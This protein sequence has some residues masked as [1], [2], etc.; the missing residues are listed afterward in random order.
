MLALGCCVLCSLRCGVVLAAL[1]ASRCSI[2]SSG[3][4]WCHTF[5]VQRLLLICWVGL[6]LE[7][8]TASAICCGFG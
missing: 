2:C 3:N 6:D 1:L 7:A 4:Y 8:S 5:R